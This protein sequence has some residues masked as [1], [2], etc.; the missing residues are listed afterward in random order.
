[1]ND[2]AN[3]PK[4]SR[5][6]KGLSAL[7]GEVDSP[8]PQQA[9][10]PVQQF[11]PN[12]PAVGS[13]SEISIDL[14]TRNPSQ[15]R[16]TFGEQELKE[17][18]HS[19][20]TKGVLQ[21]I[22]VRPDPNAPGKYQIIAGERRFRAAKGIGLTSIPAVIKQVDELELLEVGIIVRTFSARISIRWK[23]LRHTKS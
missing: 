3:A 10:P 22:L 18:A 14:I 15:P 11:A 5:L 9:S 2:P 13:V 17:L 16:K 7:M 20:K 23:R 19:I 21:A 1:M 12:Q 4:Q 8:P 6:G